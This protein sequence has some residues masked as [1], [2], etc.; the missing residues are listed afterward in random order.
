[1]ADNVTQY[2]NGL[3]VLINNARYP[4]SNGKIDSVVE[5]NDWFITGPFDTGSTSSKKYS[6][7]HTVAANSTSHASMRLFND[8]SSTS[9]DYWTVTVNTRR[10]LSETFRTITSV[11]RYI[12]FSIKKSDAVDIWCYCHNTNSFVFKAENIDNRLSSLIQSR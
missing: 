3:P 6:F 12:T 10:L 11:G 8:I 9:A 5:D 7:I 2:I 1:M 4:Q